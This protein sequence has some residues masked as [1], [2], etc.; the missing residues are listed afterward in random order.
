M[1]EREEDQ[2][3]SKQKLGKSN[4]GEPQIVCKEKGKQIKKG[5]GRE[6]EIG[7]FE[8]LE[9]ASTQ[10]LLVGTA[11]KSEIRNSDLK[12]CSKGFGGNLG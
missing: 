6:V 12:K 5:L 11:K 4:L 1:E 10:S 3:H 7:R 8:K 9:K 2:I